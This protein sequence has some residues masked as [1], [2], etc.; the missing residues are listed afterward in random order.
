[1]STIT[2]AGGFYSR[3]KMV[4]AHRFFPASAVDI[5]EVL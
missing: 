5:F 1:M 4:A 3:A 2:I